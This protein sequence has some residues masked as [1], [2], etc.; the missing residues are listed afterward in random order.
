LIAWMRSGLVDHS[1]RRADGATARGSGESMR[2]PAPQGLGHDCFHFGRGASAV[3]PAKGPPH[4]HAQRCP[5]RGSGGAGVPISAPPL[6]ALPDGA[7]RARTSWQ[8]GTA[9][10][11]RRVRT[12]RCPPANYAAYLNDSDTRAR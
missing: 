2:R 4:D 12:K 9:L 10:G 6:H 1:F 11:G 8:A 7:G 5:A 3:R